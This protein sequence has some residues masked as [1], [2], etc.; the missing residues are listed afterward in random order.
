MNGRLALLRTYF[1]ELNERPHTEDD[2]W[3]IVSKEKIDVQFW[4]LRRSVKGF[5]GI[6]RQATRNHKYIVLNANLRPHEW[7]L[8]AFH[9]L[10]HYVLHVP[11]SNLAV[12]FSR[13]GRSESFDREADKFARMLLIPRTAL[14]ELSSTY[15]E[16][17]DESIVELLPLRIKDFE[18]SGE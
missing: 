10:V 13:H 15:Y 16:F 2:F 11:E 3:Q 9:E 14:P 5:F 6:N 4:N 8:T 1:P 18:R 7:L 17:I 12:Y